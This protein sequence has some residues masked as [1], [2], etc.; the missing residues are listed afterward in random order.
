MTVSRHYSQRRFNSVTGQMPG[1][2]GIKKS[3]FSWNSQPEA[4]SHLEV[5]EMPAITMTPDHWTLTAEMQKQKGN[6]RQWPPAKD[7]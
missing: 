1:L 2:C 6:I 3:I 4:S 5:C 7:H